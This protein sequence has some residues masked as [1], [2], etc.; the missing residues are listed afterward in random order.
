MAVDKGRSEEED[1]EDEVVGVYWLLIYVSNS[2][3][4]SLKEW[5][6]VIL[7]Q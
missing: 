4:W 7:L 6:T 5:K 3:A 2:S 1:S